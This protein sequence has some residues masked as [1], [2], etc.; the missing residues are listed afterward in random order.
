[1]NFLFKINLQIYIIFLFLIILSLSFYLYFS[2]DEEI[3][4]INEFRSDV[5]IINPRFT[6][7]K[8]NKD[9]LEV[10]AKKASFISKN[11]IFLEGDV[12]FKSSEFILESDMKNFN[13]VSFDASSE[14]K[15]FFKSKKLQITSNGFDVKNKGEIINF[16]GKSNILI[17]WKYF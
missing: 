7:E 2:F 3:E 13:Q 12:K 11:R 14:E 15:T 10:I 5:D 4:K 8:S 9:N 6:K 17:Q 1:M 16:K